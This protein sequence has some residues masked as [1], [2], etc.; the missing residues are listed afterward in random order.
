MIRYIL[1][2]SCLILYNVSFSQ[3]SRDIARDGNKNY[4]RGLFADSEVD[5]RKSLSEN[6]LFEEAQFNLSDALF[7]QERYDESIN[8]LTNLIN[9]T[10]NTEI[11]ADSYYNLGNNFLQ[12]KKITEAI[13]SYKDCL[14]INPSDEEARYNLSKA[15]S[16]LDNQEQQ[17]DNENEDNSEQNEEEKDQNSGE[18]DSPEEDDQEKDNDS[19]GQEKDNNSD[20][21]N[22]EQEQSNQEN[23]SNEDLSRQEMERILDALER[24]EEKVQEEIKKHKL[25]GGDQ[26]VEKDW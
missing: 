10:Q 4:E 26:K 8:L 19:D 3:S 17:E 11:K 13:D 14:R 1:L 12:Q 9:T 18:T 22:N 20:D 7:K 6:K 15:M 25:K 5:Y 24:E 2:L 23:L 21:N 16:I